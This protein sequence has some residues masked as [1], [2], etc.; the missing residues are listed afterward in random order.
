TVGEPDWPTYGPAKEAGIKAINDNKTTYTPA[1]GIPDLK[2]SI[3]NLIGGQLN[4]EIK[5]SEVTVG[6]GAKF[7][8]YTAFTAILD[9][10]QEVI[11]PSP[12]WVSYPTM[13]ELAGGV[14]KVVNCGSESDFKLTAAQLKEA[15]GP[16]TKALLLNSP[17]NP[18]GA[19]YTKSELEDIVKVLDENPQVMIVSDD[20]YKQLSFN[21]TGLSP[22]ILHIN[23][24]L[25]DRCISINGMSKAYSMT[26][27]RIGWAV[28]NETVIKA[29]ASFQ[30]QT[31]GAPSSISQW[32]SVSA[33]D[34]CVS[35]VKQSLVNLQ[36]R[37]AFFSDLLSQIPGMKPFSPQGAFYSWVNVQDW[38]GK[39]YKGETVNDSRVLSQ[40][41]L[42]DEKLAVVPGMEFGMDGYL[43]LSFAASPKDLETAAQRFKNFQSQLS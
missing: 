30:S 23:P 32:A 38:M 13:V 41:L 34:D 20:I 17:S 39:S 10:G 26:G 11:V 27:W 6:A 24:E 28:G 33:I 2:K 16:Q 18:T 22:H 5:P 3:A 29:M 15:I 7:I 37:K 14:A 1:S 42:E 21:G 12:Y 25:F 31:T 40:K 9:P 4:R 19:E 8:I 43:R 36:E 35:E